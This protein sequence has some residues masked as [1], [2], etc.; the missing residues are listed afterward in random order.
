M[1]ECLFDFSFHDKLQI[2]KLVSKEKQTNVAVILRLR[3]YYKSKSL[4]SV[5]F[6][7]YPLK[8]KKNLKLQSCRKRDNAHTLPTLT[9]VLA[10]KSLFFVFHKS[11]VITALAWAILK[12]HR[13]NS[14]ICSFMKILCSVPI[15]PLTTFK[16]YKFNL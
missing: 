13:M 15:P 11:Q 2:I 9:N 8:Y 1:C 5:S 12:Q 3:K 16:K 7:I 14:M 4:V 6:R 10:V